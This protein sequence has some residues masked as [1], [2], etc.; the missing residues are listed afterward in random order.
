VGRFKKPPIPREE[1][2]EE[3]VA[4]GPPTVRPPPPA[5]ADWSAAEPPSGASY[6]ALRES[7]R[8]KAKSEPGDDTDHDDE[9]AI[10]AE[11]LRI[12]LD[13]KRRKPV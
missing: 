7:C 4:E 12:A 8:A 2:D 9:L 13:R 6:Q 1:P 11:V 5:A 3:P 10:E